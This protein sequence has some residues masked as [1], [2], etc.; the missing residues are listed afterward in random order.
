MRFLSR[1]LIHTETFPYSFSSGHCTDDFVGPKTLHR[2][3]ET[4]SEDLLRAK[5]FHDLLLRR[6]QVRP[7]DFDSSFVVAID[8]L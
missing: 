7:G 8:P 5:R 1:A 2:T 4:F 6:L 3:Y